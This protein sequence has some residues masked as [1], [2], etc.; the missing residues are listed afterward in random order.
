MNEYGKERGIRILT[1]MIRS[2]AVL[3]P[4]ERL[5]MSEASA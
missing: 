1:L 3:L 2:S 5:L 4:P